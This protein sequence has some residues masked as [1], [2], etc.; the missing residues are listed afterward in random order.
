MWFA[1]TSLYPD[2]DDLVISTDAYTA[3]QKSG[4]IRLYVSETKYS[5]NCNFVKY[6]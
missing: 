2:T 3:I 6:Y 1:H 4:A 5:K